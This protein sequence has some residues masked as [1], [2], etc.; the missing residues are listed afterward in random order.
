MFTI[1][2]ETTRQP[3]LP[4]SPLEPSSLSLYSA[5]EDSLLSPSLPLSQRAA[6]L[7]SPFSHLSHICKVGRGISGNER[8]RRCFECFECL[9]RLSQCGKPRIVRQMKNAD[10]F[11]PYAF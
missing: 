1:N 6:Q 5:K 8:D 3:P 11:S 2:E 4:S 10:R 7:A 9:C